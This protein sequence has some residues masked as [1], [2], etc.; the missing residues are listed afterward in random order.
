MTLPCDQTLFQMTSTVDNYFWEAD[1]LTTLCTRECFAA[2]DEWNIDVQNKCD[3]D[4]LVAYNKLVPAYSIAGRYFDGV[5]IA[6][7]TN[8]K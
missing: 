3:G 6:C 8:G 2:A 4:F 7:L 1:N 5:Q